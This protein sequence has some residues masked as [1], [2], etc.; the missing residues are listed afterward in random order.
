MSKEFNEWLQAKIEMHERKY[1][2][3][4]AV[5]PEIR[6]AEQHKAAFYAFKQVE[7][8]LWADENDRLTHRDM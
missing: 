6:V 1:R 8:K 3:A 5:I 7:A 4:M 2:D